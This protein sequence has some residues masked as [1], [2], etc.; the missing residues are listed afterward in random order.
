MLALHLQL[1][2]AGAGLDLAS[3]ASPRRGLVPLGQELDSFRTVVQSVTLQLC[4]QL[5]QPGVKGFIPAG[6]FHS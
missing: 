3:Q 2:V 4:G 1:V 5:W 6:G